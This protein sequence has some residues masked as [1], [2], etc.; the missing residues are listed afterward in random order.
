MPQIRATTAP[1]PTGEPAFLMSDNEALSD[2]RPASGYDAIVSERDTLKGQI[3][4]RTKRDARTTLFTE[5]KVDP[6]LLES[7][8][9]VYGW[10]QNGVPEAEKQTFEQW[11]AD[12]E[13]GARKH[14]LLADKFDAAP[15][16]PPNPEAGSGNNNLPDPG[17][18]NSNTPPPPKNGKM[19]NVDLQAVFSSP[20]YQAMTPT[21]K[22]AKIAQLKGGNFG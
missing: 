14:V 5:A 12:A 2:T 10:S 3:E 13:N 22:R 17:A 11:F 7:F 8:E 19:T 1:A 20:A 9:Q 21:E 15:A 6:A 18:G 4:A 16:P